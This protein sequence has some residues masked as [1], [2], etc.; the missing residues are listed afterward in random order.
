M[1]VVGLDRDAFGE[2]PFCVR[3]GEEGCVVFAHTSWLGEGGEVGEGCWG[4]RFEARD[5]GVD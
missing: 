3:A 2:Y 4:A 1:E 5:L